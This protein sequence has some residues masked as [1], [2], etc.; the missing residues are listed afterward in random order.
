MGWDHATNV[1]ISRPTP[2]LA[3]P[4]SEAVVSSE[5]RIAADKALD[6]AATSP[7]IAANKEPDVV[8]T[9]PINGYHKT[10]HRTKTRHQSRYL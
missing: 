10:L 1:P 9:L 4:C 7:L 5:G 2:T 6:I 3:G 8:V